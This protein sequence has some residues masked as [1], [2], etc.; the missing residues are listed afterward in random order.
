[1]LLQCNKPEARDQHVD[2]HTWKSIS[3]I[4]S[5]VLSFFFFYKER[6]EKN[7][8]EYNVR[9]ETLKGSERTSKETSI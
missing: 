7:Q 2:L 9:W 4:I 5:F 3:L 1:M 8:S 6:V